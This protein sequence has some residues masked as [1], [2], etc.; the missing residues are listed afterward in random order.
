LG[1]RGIDM[2]IGVMSGLNAMISYIALFM[3]AGS[4]SMGSLFI[5]NLYCNEELSVTLA[6]RCASRQ[7]SSATKLLYYFYG[8]RA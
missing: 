8:L 1:Q 7:N 4:I 6:D 5:F 2:Q 3:I